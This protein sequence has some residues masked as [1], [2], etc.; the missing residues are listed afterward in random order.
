MKWIVRAIDGRRELVELVQAP[1]VHTPVVLV[2]PVG[3]ELFQ[4]REIRAIYT[5]HCRDLFPGKRAR[6]RRSVR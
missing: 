4:M 6:R 3:H 1:F 5:V 2:A